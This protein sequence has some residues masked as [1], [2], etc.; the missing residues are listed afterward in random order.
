MQQ[1]SSTT[2][3]LDNGS[4][5]PE[6]TKNLRWVA[7]QLSERLV[8]P[9]E[10]ISIAHSDQV[11]ADHLDGKPAEVLPHFLERCYKK[12]ITHV[13]IIPF[14]FAEGGGI[15]KLAQRKLRE[16]Q[17]E[18]PELTYSFTRFPYDESQPDNLHV[19]RILSIRIQEAIRQHGLDRPPVILVDHGSP[20]PQAAYVR[21]M[22]CGQVNALCADTIG[23]IGAASMERRDGEQYAFNDPLLEDRLKMSGYDFGNV[24]VAMLFLS[25]GRHAGAGGDVE[26][27]CKAA[28][29]E[30]SDNAPLKTL[31]TELVGT[32]PDIV[33]VLATRYHQT[34]KAASKSGGKVST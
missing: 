33:D 11:E 9:V 31:M 3:L 13:N 16:C 25:P 34:D 4:I 1:P 19:A 10:P 22:I 30:S 5:N 2:I 26:S 15:V 8:F 20:L 6:A 12:G 14:F 23:P 27:I 28:E 29:A 17:R 18:M 32:H 7:G 24:I 21:N